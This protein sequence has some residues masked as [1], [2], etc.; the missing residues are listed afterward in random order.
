[1]S[2]GPEKGNQQ[3]VNF[4]IGE[5]EAEGLY[6]NLALVMHSNAEF[7]VDFTR[8]LPG[9]PKAKVQARIIMTPI[10]TKLLMNALHDNIDKYEQKYGEIKI[11]SDPQQ[12]FT[13]TPP[14][15]AIN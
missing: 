14:D 5:K 11:P 3:Q 4:E 1:M 8:I 15:S 9:V 12:I 10:H 6:S 2:N 7:I 13:G